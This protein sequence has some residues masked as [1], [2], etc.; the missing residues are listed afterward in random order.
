VKVL[1]IVKAQPIADH[2]LGNE[3]VRH[4]MQID[5][6]IFERAPET[7]PSPDGTTVVIVPGSDEQIYLD[8]RFGT[9]K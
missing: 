5:R 1:G 8:V 9:P 7:L 2:P 6:L 4:L 3:A